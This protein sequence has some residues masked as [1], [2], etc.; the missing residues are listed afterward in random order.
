MLAA[1]AT[2]SPGDDDDDDDDDD[3]NYGHD[4]NDNDDDHSNDGNGD[5]CDASTAAMKAVIVTIITK[6]QDDNSSPF[7]VTL[8]RPSPKSVDYA[9]SVSPRS[10]F[11]IVVVVV[12]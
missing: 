9:N 1:T 10:S 6:A 8:A 3:E 2:A 5:D 11:F 7:P 4:D 12:A